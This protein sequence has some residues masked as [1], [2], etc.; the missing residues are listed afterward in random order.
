MHACTQ[1]ALTHAQNKTIQTAQPLSICLRGITNNEDD[2]SVDVLRT[3]TW[4]LL[5]QLS[6]VEDG[7]EFKTTQRGAP[8]KV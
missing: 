4:P 1:L 6:G 3:V 8:P 5:R 7:W 2:L